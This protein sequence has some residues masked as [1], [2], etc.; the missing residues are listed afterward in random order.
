[1]DVRLETDRLTLRRLTKA[2][3]DDLLALHADPAV[4][5]YLGPPE[6]YEKVR[7]GVLPSLLH[8][9]DRSTW[10]GYWAAVERDGGGFLGWFLFRPPFDDP[11]DGE[12]EIGYR[13]NRAA[14]GRGF[15]TEGARALL[16]DGFAE[17]GVERVM[18]TTM[19]LNAGSRRVMEKIGLRFVRTY[20]LEFDDPLPGT[21]E[22]EVEYALTREEWQ[23]SRT[24]SAPA[25]AP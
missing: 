22:G 12:I 23:R 10:Q 19:T 4:M 15:A 24:P 11:A 9:Y 16:D 14:W 17:H 20:H 7:D 3:L 5:R 21:E 6:S 13:L 25:S 18:A 1:M 8:W 2:D